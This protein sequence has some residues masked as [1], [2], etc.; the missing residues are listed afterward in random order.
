MCSAS[1]FTQ[2]DFSVSRLAKLDY[3]CSCGRRHR[4]P[5]GDI[6]VGSGVLEELPGIVSSYKGKNV[7]LIG[8]SHTFP[9]AGERVR[10]LLEKAGLR[11]ETHIFSRRE[12]YV[13]D[14]AAIGELLVALPQDTELIVTVGSG[15][16]NDVTRAVSTRCRLPYM[17]IGTAPSMDG[18][19][20]ST[21]AIICGDEKRSVPLS[22]PRGIVMDTDLLVT[23]PEEMLS[24]GIG[25]VLGKHVTLADW[26]LAARE[27]REH[28]CGELSDL[29]ELACRRCQSNYR[30]VLTRDPGAVGYMADTL[31]MA[32]AAISMFGTSR[33]CAGSEHALAHVWEVD[34]I[35]RG[36]Q[37]PLHGNFVGLGT[38]AAILLYRE[39]G[40]EFDFS[41]LHYTLPDPEDIETILREAGGWALRERL[42]VDRTGFLAAFEH[43]ARTNPRYTILTFLHEKGC[44]DRF[45]AAVTGRIYG[46]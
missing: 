21:S 8:D 4:V 12:H 28:Y 43:A 39:A 33:P 2:P 44:L 42:G 26:R 5:I 30:G 16:M 14:E 1:F 22:S 9:L 25:D 17:I 40:R 18:Y 45:A 19:A 3:P 7:L 29:I 34:A 27:G 11:V 37:S 36:G 41:D 31:V 38:I 10:A 32:G 13:T 46:C 35:R 15:T 24:A 23:A 20:S 6:A